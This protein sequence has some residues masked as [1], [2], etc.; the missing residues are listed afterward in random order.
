LGA[1]WV[2]LHLDNYISHKDSAST[3]YG[4]TLGNLYE[5]IASWCT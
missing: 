2:R 3:M 5:D 1:S 4:L